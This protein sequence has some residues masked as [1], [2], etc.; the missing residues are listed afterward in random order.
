MSS[1]Y[2]LSGAPTR[3]SADS[4]SP[5]VTETNSTQRPRVSARRGERRGNYLIRFGAEA[6]TRTPT[7]LRALDPETGAGDEPALSLSA[8]FPATMRDCAPIARSRSERIGPI[9]ARSGPVG[10]A[11]RKT[12]HARSHNG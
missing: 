10:R 5:I 12:D 1:M 6:G 9:G 8:E 2:F 7:P 4:R 3:S 11:F